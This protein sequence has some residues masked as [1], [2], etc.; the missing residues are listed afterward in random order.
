VLYNEHL[1]LTK[2]QF[3]I[4][5]AAWSMPVWYTRASEEHE[6]VRKGAGLFD[7]S[8]MGRL[9]IKG[10]YA[11]RFLDLVTTNF[12]PKLALGEAHYS[13]ILDA[14]GDVMDDIFLYY[15]NINHYLMIA[16]A[17]NAE[18]IK[19]W[20]IAVN[21]RKVT[22]DRDHPEREVEGKVTITDVRPAPENPNKQGLNVNM[23]LQGPKSMEVLLRLIKG[24][25]DERRLLNLK[26]SFVTEV[27]L[28]GIKSLVAR[29]GYTGEEIGFEI[30]TDAVDAPKFWNMILEE[31][32][33]LGVKATGLA[34]RDS[35]RTEAGLPLYGHE[36]AG[37]HNISSTET[38]YGSFIKRHKPF[39]VGRSSY[40]AR[41][42]ESKKTVVRFEIMAQGVRAI[43]PEDSVVDRKGAN[44]GVVTSCTLV[45]GKQIG[46]AHV[47]K[48]YAAEGTKIAIF[49]SSVKK[50]SDKALPAESAVVVSRFP[51]RV[52]VGLPALEA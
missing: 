8:H 42:A 41:E 38:G 35:T 43:K 12:V 51:L 44:I 32:K 49:R 7:V 29:T 21:E 28:G 48:S 14:N 39:F 19:Q 52:P 34:A 40:L 37:K 3:L 1:K 47:D 46:L 4:P 24:V 9:E 6:A 2:K 13:Y 20:L 26:R 16:N 30:M 50:G 33:D 36:L 25:K 5:F 18:K 15:L 45:S 10:A 27:T 11:T 31:G 22:L 17:A 23:A